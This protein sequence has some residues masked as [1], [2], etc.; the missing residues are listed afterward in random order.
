MFKRKRDRK[1][2]SKML[3]IIA[4]K[5][6]GM[7]SVNFDEDSLSL[8]DEAEFRSPFNN[9]SISKF[10]DCSK[11]DYEL[12][13]RSSVV[14]A[15]GKNS[16]YSHIFNIPRTSKKLFRD[17]SSKPTILV[18]LEPRIGSDS[19]FKD[20][21]APRKDSLSSKSVK[22]VLSASKIRK[23]NF[24]IP[25]T[26][27]LHSPHGNCYNMIVQKSIKNISDSKSKLE[28]IVNNVPR[29]LIKRLTSKDDNEDEASPRSQLCRT[30]IYSD[31]DV[32]RV[33]NTSR[34]KTLQRY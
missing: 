25:N 19:K 34:N 24:C 7:Q 17:S 1:F 12:N 29:Q 2:T 21:I 31:R 10:P 14:K 13:L 33:L 27:T 8:N 22:S 6:K 18:N 16:E 9:P 30:G 5:F 32:L 20:L 28:K 15:R 11:Q 4:D 3:G 26:S 23:S